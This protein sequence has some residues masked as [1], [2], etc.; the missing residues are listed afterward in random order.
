M[1]VAS[2]WD[3]NLMKSSLTLRKVIGITV[4]RGAAPTEQASD[5]IEL[6]S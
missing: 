3:V 4:L 2:L 5:R 1:G 6:A